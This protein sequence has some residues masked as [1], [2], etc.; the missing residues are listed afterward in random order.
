MFC[1][2]S[3]RMDVF[4]LLMFW[5]VS[6]HVKWHIHHEKNYECKNGFSLVGPLLFG[7]VN[8]VMAVEIK[9]DKEIVTKHPF[10]VFKK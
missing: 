8:F 5:N 1:T 6:L 2:L 3:H 7:Y 4:G 10:P 9:D